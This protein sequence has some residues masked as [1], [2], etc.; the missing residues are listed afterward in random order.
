MSKLKIDDPY[1][2]V[3]AHILLD[4]ANRETARIALTAPYGRP[5]TRDAD[6]KPREHKIDGIAAGRAT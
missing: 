5:H 2:S 1:V 6:V 3:A 4:R